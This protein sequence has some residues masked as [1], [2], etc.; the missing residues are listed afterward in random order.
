MYINEHEQRF[1]PNGTGVII[2]DCLTMTRIMNLTNEQ[3]QQINGYWQK[4]QTIALAHTAINPIQL[5]PAINTWYQLAN[6]ELPELLF[7]N[8]PSPYYAQAFLDTTMKSVRVLLE[9]DWRS[10]PEYIF[11]ENPGSNIAGI[12]SQEF[13]LPIERVSVFNIKRV[14]TADEQRI[15]NTI[16]QVDR[17]VGRQYNISSKFKIHLRQSWFREVYEQLNHNLPIPIEIKRKLADA[18]DSMDLWSGCYVGCVDRMMLSFAAARLEYLQSILA[19]PTNGQLAMI[20]ALINGGG[21]M[22]FPYEKICIICKLP[23]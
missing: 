8:D 6:R 5:T 23:I 11:W 9:N 16:A 17:Y 2:N 12:L 21:S 4:W 15:L 22:I 19:L 14:K 20:A 18:G 13:V 1:S 10:R 7:V 3:L